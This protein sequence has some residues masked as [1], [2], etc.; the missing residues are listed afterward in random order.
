MPNAQY[1][2]TYYDL[3]E[4]IKEAMDENGINIPYPRMDVRVEN[5]KS[6]TP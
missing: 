2:S 4:N 6:I 1:W 5:V 3:L